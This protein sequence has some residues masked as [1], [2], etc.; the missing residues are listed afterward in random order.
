MS[1]KGWGQDGGPGLGQ[2]PL[3]NYF[4]ENYFVDSKNVGVSAF[5]GS[6]SIFENLRKWS[7]ACA[8]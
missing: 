1:Q 8:F 5:A 3:A 7:L 6:T 4:V 2:G